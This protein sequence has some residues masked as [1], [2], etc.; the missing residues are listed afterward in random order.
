MSLGLCGTNDLDPALDV[1]LGTLTSANCALFLRSRYK[2]A[3]HP[4][5]A[6]L[7]R[8]LLL[9]AGTAARA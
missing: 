8:S 3:A 4:S 1:T 2:S 6:D 5:S 9:S 7:T